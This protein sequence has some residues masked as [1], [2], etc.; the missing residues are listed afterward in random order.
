[1]AKGKSEVI[2]SEKLYVVGRSSFLRLDKPKAFEEGQEPRYEGTAL[3][4]PSDPKRKDELKKMISE[5]GRIAK[6]K[7]GFVP[8]AVHQVAVDLGLAKALPAGIKEDGVKFDCLYDGNKKDYEGYADRWVLAMHNKNKPAVAN[9]AGESVL[10]GEDQFPYSGCHSRFSFTFWTQDNK[11][12]KRIGVNL[13]GVQFLRDDKAF[14]A[15]NIDAAS[16]F[17]ALD[18]PADATGDE[19]SPFGD[20]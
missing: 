12:G 19:D 10:P 4:D 15:G 3:V 6:A 8:K 9:R 11:F 16:E 13:R 20:D 5:A 17:D 2:T 18:E 14:A 7:W 1:M